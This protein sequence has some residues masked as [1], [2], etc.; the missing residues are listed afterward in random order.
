MKAKILN[1]LKSGRIVSGEDLSRELGISRVSIWKHIQ[2]LKELGYDIEAGAR[3]YQSRGTMDALYPWE[4]PGREDR[5]HFSPETSST[6]DVARD[7]ASRGCPE[8]TVAVAGIQKNGRGRMKREWHSLEGGLYFTLVLRPDLPMGFSHRINF[9]ASTI[10]TEVLH[11]EF[12]IDAR[13]KWP[14]D[15]LVN[16]KKISGMLS[17]IVAETDMVHYI[18]I[19]MGVNVNNDPTRYEPAATSM[20]NILGKPTPRKQVLIAFLNRFESAMNN[21]EWKNA[22]DRWR[23]HTVTLNRPVKITTTRETSEGMARDV[24]QDGAL[25]LELKDGSLKR[26]VYGDCFHA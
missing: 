26:I 11:H 10:M 22:V 16:E 23:Q 20:I 24:D 25:I 17:E 12:R 7:M 5:I 9:L 8:F 15:I 1:I 18:N 2:G 4:F 21:R 6:M 19:G 14:N 3:G 13:V